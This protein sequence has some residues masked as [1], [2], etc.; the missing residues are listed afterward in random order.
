[1]TTNEEVENEITKENLVRI[2]L[3][4]SLPMLSDDARKGLGYSREE[5]LSKQILMS[6]EQL[7]N[8]LEVQEIFNLF[9]NF[10]H[11]MMSS[12]VTVNQ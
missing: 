12:L 8:R 2:R 5:N 6:Q 9:H 4:Y 1:M 7:C 11:R 3:A 10:K